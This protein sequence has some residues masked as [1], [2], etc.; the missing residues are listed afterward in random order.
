MTQAFRDKIRELPPSKVKQ[1][2]VA[3]VR[4]CTSSRCVTCSKLRKRVLEYKEKMAAEIL[5]GLHKNIY[6]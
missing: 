3:H 4:G 6:S 1:L 5:Y 2:L